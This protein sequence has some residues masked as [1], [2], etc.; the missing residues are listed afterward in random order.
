MSTKDWR[1]NFLPPKRTTHEVSGVEW[2]FYPISVDCAIKLRSLGG[3]LVSALTVLFARN[4]ND[5]RQIVREFDAS[6]TESAGRESVVEAISPELATLRSKE[7]RDALKEAV[8]T[9]FDPENKNMVGQVLM[10][11]L[12]DMFPRDT[13]R[14]WP[15]AQ[16]FMKHFDVVTLREAVVGLIKAN[17]EVFGPFAKKITEVIDT[18]LSKAIDEA[19]ANHQAGNEQDSETPGEISTTPSLS[20]SE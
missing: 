1:K 11:S 16:E 5:V 20:L 19:V 3:P 2:Q 12:R 4:S 13:R 17:V 18:V 7:R 15:P 8:D 10:D 14:D 9:V 6:A